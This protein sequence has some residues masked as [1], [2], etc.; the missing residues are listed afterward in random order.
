VRPIYNS[1]G[2]AGQERVKGFSNPEFRGKFAPFS[3]RSFT[4]YSPDE[5]EVTPK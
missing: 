5:G 3:L 1:N 4:G 2:V